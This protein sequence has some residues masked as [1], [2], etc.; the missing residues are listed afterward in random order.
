MPGATRAVRATAHCY[1]RAVMRMSMI[2]TTL[3]ALLLALALPTA[4]GGLRQASDLSADAHDAAQRAVPILVMFNAEGCP[5]CHVVREYYVEPLARDAQF[6]D[7]VILRIVNVDSYDP[8]VD[9]D[10]TL[11]DHHSFASKNSVTLTPV[12]KF[13]GPDG[14]ELVK[15][16]VG[17]STEDFYGWYLE[18]RLS[19][20]LDQLQ[21][22]R[23]AS[24]R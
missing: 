13:F 10:G 3:A 21:T 24:N 11:T 2:K 6:H 20:A 7:R 4:A 19:D 15:E 1:N 18:Q 23:Q 8:L 22:N 17:L 14:R 5:Y 12:V 9:F 16:L